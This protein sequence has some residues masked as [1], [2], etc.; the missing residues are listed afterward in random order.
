[1]EL[2]VGDVEAWKTFLLQSIFIY[3]ELYSLKVTKV[4]H[5][6]RKNV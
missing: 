5:N 3:I 1:M 2:L 6:K 4:L